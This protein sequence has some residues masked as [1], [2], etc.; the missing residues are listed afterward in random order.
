MSFAF[1][2]SVTSAEVKDLV[3]L[4][5][6]FVYPKGYGRLEA[7]VCY[8]LGGCHAEW[9]QGAFPSPSEG[10]PPV[11]APPAPGS[12]R[13]PLGAGEA[14]PSKGRTPHGE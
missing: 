7:S 4:V 1:V 2:V 6:G 5:A 3:C 10:L 9:A 14:V 12:G 11:P 13:E 8:L